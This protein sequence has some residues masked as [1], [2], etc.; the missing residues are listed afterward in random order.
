MYVDGWSQSATVV[1]KLEQDN[2]VECAHS[3]SPMQ[4]ALTLATGGVLTTATNQSVAVVCGG[5]DGNLSN[6][7]CLILTEEERT[8]QRSYEDDEIFISAHGILNYE[9]V[10]S[11][12]LVVEDGS[13]LWLAGGQK[14]KL[15]RRDSEFVSFFRNLS[16]FSTNAA[17]PALPKGVYHHCLQKIGP[18]MAVV[19]GGK[20]GTYEE[21]GDCLDPESSGAKPERSEG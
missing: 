11:G 14:E 16:A 10:G 15:S 6:K 9:R 13:S 4:Q 3:I 12:S 5:E 21:K 17:G 1:L 7:K 19:I 8:G 2:V 20:Q 18:T